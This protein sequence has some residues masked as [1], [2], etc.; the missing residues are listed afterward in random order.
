MP[1][2]PGHVVLHIESFVGVI[3]D[4][5]ISIPYMPHVVMF[6]SKYMWRHHRFTGPKLTDLDS[7]DDG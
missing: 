3:E 7:A 4:S 5:E 2:L 6:E 1:N